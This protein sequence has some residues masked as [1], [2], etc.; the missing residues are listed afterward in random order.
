VITEVQARSPAASAGLREGDVVVAL[1]GRPMHSAV[2]MRARL[3][4]TPVGQTIELRVLRGAGE[5]TLRVRI[6]EVEARHAGRG[7]ALAELAGATLADAKS[8]EDTGGEKA[9]LV[10]AVRAD[11]RAFQYGLRPG[12]VIVGVNRRR[13]R[14]VAEL[15]KALRTKGRHALNV[16]R[17]DFLLAIVVR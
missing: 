16:V 8:G 14:S 12:D 10:T 7:E 1:D 11:T 9:V 15:G 3:A 4:V 5:K 2:Q 6:A 17:G 13:V